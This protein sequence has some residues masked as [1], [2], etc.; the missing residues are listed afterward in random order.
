[1]ARGF[2]Q[3]YSIDYL[4]TF[5]PTL[6]QDYIRI[7]IL[8]AIYYDFEIYQ[9]D[10]KAVYLNADLEEELYM[11]IPEECVDYGK[12]FWKLDKA[13]YG[14]KQSGRMWN[15]KLDTV[16]TEIGFKRLKSEPCVYI[17]KDKYNKIICIIAIYVDDLL[18]SGR[19]RTIDIIKSKIKRK[20]DLSDLDT[21]DFIIGIKFIKCKDSYIVHQLS[22]LKDILKRFK[23][24]KYNEISN[25]MYTEDEKLRERKFDKTTYMQAVGCLL[26]LAMETR[27]DIMFATSKA[28]R[29]NQNPTFEDWM[30]LIKIFRYLKGTK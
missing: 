15:N 17:L 16:L 12:G 5:Y 19:K 3:I 30:N 1:V 21:V 8:I 7:I 27:P 11:K 25:M 23:I 28:S 4:E 29:K 9:M 26:Y 22:Y 13:I 14:L 20:I 2:S 24:D 18:I 10:I 6:K